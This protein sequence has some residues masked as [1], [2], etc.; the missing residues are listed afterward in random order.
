MMKLTEINFMEYCEMYYAP[1]GGKGL[2]VAIKVMYIQWKLGI[3]A[4]ISTYDC[5]VYVFTWE[6]CDDYPRWY[7]LE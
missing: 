1:R 6:L 7:H 4:H 5:Y 3:L 2:E